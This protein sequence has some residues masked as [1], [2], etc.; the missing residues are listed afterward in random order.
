MKLESQVE[1]KYGQNITLSNE[2]LSILPKDLSNVISGNF[3]CYDNLIRSHILGLMFIE[4]DGSI[5]SPN[6]EDNLNEILNKWKNRG[7]RG[8]IAM[9]TRSN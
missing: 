9:S 4:M 7:R 8:V 5:F 3:D 1:T 2:G 6:I